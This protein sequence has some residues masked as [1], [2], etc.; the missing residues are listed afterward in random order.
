MGWGARWLAQE[1]KAMRDIGG[2]PCAAAESG[3]SAAVAID[4]ATVRRLN[5]IITEK[6]I[7]GV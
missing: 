5:M 7:S 2:V 1:P 3:G 6:P 4:C